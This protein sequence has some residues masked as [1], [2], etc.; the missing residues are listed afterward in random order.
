MPSSCHPRAGGDPGPQAQNGVFPPWIPGQ[1]G[2]D[3]KGNGDDSVRIK[4]AAVCDSGFFIKLTFLILAVNLAKH[5][6][7]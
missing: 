5:D 2:D 4:K 1:A 6:I 3:K 7:H